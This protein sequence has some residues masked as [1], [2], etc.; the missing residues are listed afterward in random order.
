MDSYYTI[1]GKPP[2]LFGLIMATMYVFHPNM[3]WKFEIT[4]SIAV[5]LACY[6]FE[7]VYDWSANWD[8]S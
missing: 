4:G 7:M 2:E 5:I 8:R 6:I 1:F 3:K